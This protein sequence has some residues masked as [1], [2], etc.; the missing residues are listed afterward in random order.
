MGLL[1]VVLIFCRVVVTTTRVFLQLGLHDDIGPILAMTQS[2]VIYTVPTTNILDIVL[3]S[4]TI[5]MLQ[6]FKL[7][8]NNCIQIHNYK[9]NYKISIKILL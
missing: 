1:S 8:S 7:K 3:F 4:L 2:Y 5:R 9:N 6:L